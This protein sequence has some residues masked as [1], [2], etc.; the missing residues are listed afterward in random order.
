MIIMMIKQLKLFQRA[1]Y[2]HLVT[3]RLICKPFNHLTIIIII[4]TIVY[5]HNAR[6]IS[7][8]SDSTLTPHSSI[9]KIYL[10]FFWRGGS[11]RLTICLNF[12]HS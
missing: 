11:D 1:L 4:Y 7:F 12:S 2:S 5:S 8:A 9:V 3:R 6:I 10:F